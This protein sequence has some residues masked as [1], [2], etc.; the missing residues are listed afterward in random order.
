MNTF[1]EYWGYSVGFFLACAGLLAPAVI[2]VFVIFVL[3]VIGTFLYEFVK[4]LIEEV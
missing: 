2:A 3:L 1:L 4:W